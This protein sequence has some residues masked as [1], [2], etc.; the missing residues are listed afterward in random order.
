MKKPLKWTLIIIGGLFVLILAAAI[1][2]P[3]VFKDD[4]KAAIDKEL[5]KSVNADVVFEDFSV[6]F[7]R[8]FPNVTA[9]LHDLGVLNRAPFEGQVLFATEEFEVEVNLMDILF[10]DQLRVKGISLIRPVINIKV[11]EEGKANYDIA[12]PSADTTTS[13]AESEDF[14]FGIDHWEIVDGDISYDDRTLPYLLF[15]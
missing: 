14:S 6:S 4:I 15:I 10:G 1:I 3:I 7:F 5:A 2:L 9:Q 13:E 8:H 11:N 12:I